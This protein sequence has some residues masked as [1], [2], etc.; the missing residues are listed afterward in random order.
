MPFISS[1]V[2]K[3]L[4]VVH[5]ENLPVPTSIFSTKR[6][7]RLKGTVDSGYIF[8]ISSAIN[9]TKTLTLE[10]LVAALT[11]VLA[12]DHTINHLTSWTLNPF[13]LIIN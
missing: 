2:T 5:I 8:L 10:I 12:I 13:K 7:F 9:A 3:G 1:F 11:L 4:I 6:K